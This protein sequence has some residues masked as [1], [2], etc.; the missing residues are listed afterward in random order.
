MRGS[1]A[2]YTGFVTVLG[3]VRSTDL[4]DKENHLFTY[5]SLSIINHQVG[6]VIQS[7]QQLKSRFG[8]IGV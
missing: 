3:H 5:Q 4:Q 8:E 1:L 7:D 2:G 6:H